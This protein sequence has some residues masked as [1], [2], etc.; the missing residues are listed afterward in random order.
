MDLLR[1]IDQYPFEIAIGGAF[2]IGVFLG[3]IARGRTRVSR[4]EDP[5]NK[6]IR[7]LEADLRLA[8]KRLGESEEL[9]VARAR[10]V[11]ETQGTVTDL[12]LELDRREEE[13]TR[14]KNDLK[15]AVNKT[16]ELRQE[17]TEKAAETVRERVRAKEALTEL[18]VVR[19][20]SDAMYDEYKS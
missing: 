4:T 9:L 8:E 17:L 3:F 13:A 20:G 15:G 12:Q 7:Q 10:E 14:L 1:Y 5:R 6:Q 19:A 2:V 16:R 11:E 18:E